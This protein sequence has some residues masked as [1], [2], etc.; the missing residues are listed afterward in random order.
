MIAL[1][2]MLQLLTVQQEDASFA[3]YLMRQGDFYRAITEYK[4]VSFYTADGILRDSC[5]LEIARCYR[6]SQKFDSAIRFSTS[7]IHSSSA[8]KEIRTA[9]TLNL[10]LTYLDS[11]MPQLARHYL[12]SVDSSD[13]SG[14]VH[15][16]L[17]LTEVQ[18]KQWDAASELFREAADQTPDSIFRSTILT[19][20]DEFLKRKSVG[21]KSP[22]LASALS[23]VIPGAGQAYS[24][25]YYDAT[26][27]FLFTACFA[28]ASFAIYR[29]E[30]DERNHLGWTYVGISITAMFHT[31]NVIG[32]NL[33]AR[34]RNWKL[35]N[36]VYDRAYRNV[37][38]FE[39]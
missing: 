7:L 28:F 22:L 13:S 9:A 36:D 38:K 3:R 19:I 5:A 39:R 1:L 27:S 17:A 30:H 24:G 2:I 37:M 31:A 25:H 35:D 16:C 26:Q 14:F 34:Y 18:V 12:E 10:G 21:R 20:S 15:A 33:T 8:T 23:F 6:K 11:K 4:R 32:A 29:Y